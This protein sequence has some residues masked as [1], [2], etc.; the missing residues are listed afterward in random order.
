MGVGRVY[1]RSSLSM[2]ARVAL[3]DTS[4]LNMLA[5]SLRKTSVNANDD[6]CDPRRAARLSAAGDLYILGVRC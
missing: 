5:D 6:H 2:A 4:G 1:L 3:R